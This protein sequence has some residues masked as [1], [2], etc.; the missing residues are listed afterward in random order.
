MTRLTLPP[1]LIR[2]GLGKKCSVCGMEFTSAA[3]P[4][5]SRAFR[6]HVEEAHRGPKAESGQKLTYTRPRKA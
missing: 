2:S 5:L 4:S 1:Y 3:Q 6:Q